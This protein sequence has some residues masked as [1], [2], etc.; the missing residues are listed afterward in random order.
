MGNAA[1]SPT[2][3]SSSY[4]SQPAEDR[5]HSRSIQLQI[6]RSNSTEQAYE[7]EGESE[8]DEDV[9]EEEAERSYHRSLLLGSFMNPRIGNG[10]WNFPSLPVPA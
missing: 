6:E 3:R 8:E 5:E 9:H 10:N 2:Q 4:E 7:V 1:A